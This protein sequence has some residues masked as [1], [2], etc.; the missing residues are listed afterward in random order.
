[1]IMLNHYHHHD[2]GGKLRDKATIN[3]LKMYRGGKPIRDKKGKV[4]MR[5][6]SNRFGRLVIIYLVIIY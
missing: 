4:R 2:R 1:M 5:L 3:R 6:Q